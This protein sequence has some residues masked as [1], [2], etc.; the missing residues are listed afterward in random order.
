METISN[1]HLQATFSS[2]GAETQSL[3]DAATGREYIWQADR[4]W[5]GRHS[6]LLFPITGGLWNGT[7]RFDG[8]TASIPKHGFALRREWRVDEKG[9][10]HIVFLLRPLPE[11]AAAYP[12]DYSLRV[13]YSLRERTLRADFSVENHGD[14]PMFFQIG[15]HPGINLPDFDEAH[16]ID[17]YLRL[18]G[19]PRH[20]LR[21]GEQGCVVMDHGRPA[22][23]PLPALEDGLIPLGVNTFAHEALIIEGQVTTAEVLD[24]ARR[25]FVRV[26][27][28]APVWLFWSM[29]G[30]HSPYVCCEPWYGLPDHQGFEGD[31]SAR[32]HVQQAA[33]GETWHGGYSLEVL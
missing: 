30:V 17:G 12:Y 7:A 9:S 5:W 1:H 31:F 33:P 26:E 29:Q 10:D 3:C 23:F 6:P 16:A 32:P 22:T 24:R 8:R 4:R 14:R 2:V 27:S 11:E 19:T 13:R 15:G 18:H 28:T 20:V 21:A 25:P